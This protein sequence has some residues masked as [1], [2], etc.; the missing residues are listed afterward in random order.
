MIIDSNFRNVENINDIILVYNERNSGKYIIINKIYTDKLYSSFNNIL[1]PE[2]S[3]NLEK[4]K[5][6]LES[7]GVFVHKL[8]LFTNYSQTIDYV[9]NFFLINSSNIYKIQVMK[10]VFLTKFDDLTD[11]DKAYLIHSGLEECLTLVLKHCYSEDEIKIVN[12]IE[13]FKSD[14]N[15]NIYDSISDNIFNN[16]GYLNITTIKIWECDEVELMKKYNIMKSQN[17]LSPEM[18][19]DLKD[20]I[21]ENRIYRIVIQK[22]QSA[23][24]QSILLEGESDIEKQIKKIENILD[25]KLKN[26]ESISE[27]EA[28]KLQTYCHPDKVNDASAKQKCSAELFEGDGKNT[29][30]ELTKESINQI[31]ILLNQIISLRKEEEKKTQ[32]IRRPQG[33]SPVESHEVR[34]Q[35]PELLL[36]TPPIPASIVS[37]ETF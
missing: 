3:K 29:Q 12:L 30:T 31:S 9:K 17:L 35:N 10:D 24:H 23:L 32:L 5:G 36:P 11:S 8:F 27:K 20:T 28:R 4:V 16:K 13:L 26:V 14:V 6:S 19:K 33:P 34:T 21:T 2:N 22:I 37:V 25:V 15:M 7:V 18:E 1:D